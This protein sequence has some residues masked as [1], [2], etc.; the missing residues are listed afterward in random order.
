VYISLILSNQFYLVH[1]Q[2]FSAF[3]IRDTK[4]FEEE[5]NEGKIIQPK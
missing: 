3:Q 5:K 1:L 4:K 2:Q